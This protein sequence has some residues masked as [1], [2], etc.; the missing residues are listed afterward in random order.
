[1]TASQLKPLSATYALPGI[2]SLVD[3]ECK[4]CRLDGPDRF[5]QY[6]LA[7]NPECP[8]HGGG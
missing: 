1:M 2:L 4:V 7:V 6:E 3:S 8:F 5:G